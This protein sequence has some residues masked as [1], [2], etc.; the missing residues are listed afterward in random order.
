LKSGGSCL[1][2]LLEALTA[3][4]GSALGRL[5]GH[6]SFLAALRTNRS[7]L[8]LVVALR[9]GYPQ[10]SYS[11]CLTNFATLGLVLELLVMKKQLFTRRKD[12]VRA[13]V[14]TL[15]YLVLKFH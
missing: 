7:S 2:P 11:L 9:R 10:H 3:K 4:D 14:Y 1:S 6:R 8:N 5:K 13:A 12:E 15:Q